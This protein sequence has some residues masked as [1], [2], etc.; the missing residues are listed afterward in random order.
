MRYCNLRATAV[1]AALLLLF[2]AASAFATKVQ[3]SDTSANISDQALSEEGMFSSDLN[4]QELETIITLELNDGSVPAA[5]IPVKQPVT[6]STPIEKGLKAACD[7]AR[8]FV[9]TPYRWGGTTPKAFDCSGFTRYVYSKLGVKLPR[10]AR[11]QFQ[12]GKAVKNGQWKP[13]DLI[14]F[15]MMKGY[16]SHVGMYLGSK[17][18]IHASTPRTGVRID[19]LDKAY[20]KKCYVGA[21]RFQS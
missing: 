10:T 13:G 18:F 15:D 1:I 14:F 7:I 5:P 17:M 20:Y 2:T 9:G 21:R 4:N 16:V 11:Q 19:R 3:S 12:A 8:R 6:V